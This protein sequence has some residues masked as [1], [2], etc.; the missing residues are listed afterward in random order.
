[1]ALLTSLFNGVAPH[2]K[3]WGDQGPHDY[4]STPKNEV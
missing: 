4:S 3:G 1:M 2:P